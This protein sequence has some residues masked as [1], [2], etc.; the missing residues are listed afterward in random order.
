MKLSRIILL[1]LATFPLVFSCLLWIAARWTPA[2]IFWSQQV[3]PLV[4]TLDDGTELGVAVHRC[5]SLNWSGGRIA[6]MFRQEQTPEERPYTA[7]PGFPYDVE[8]ARQV[9]ALWDQQI[10]EQI[11]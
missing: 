8:L 1:L 3:R 11:V 5:W 6:L 10:R 2:S 4:V 7:P 9:R